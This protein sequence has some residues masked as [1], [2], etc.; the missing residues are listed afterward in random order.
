MK[1]TLNRARSPLIAVFERILALAD[2]PTSRRADESN[3]NNAIPLSLSC[4]R[5]RRRVA[6]SPRRPVAPSPRARDINESEPA[7]RRIGLEARTRS[8]RVAARGW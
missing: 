1:S 3:D 2:E 8:V 4:I 7:A 6:P 5:T